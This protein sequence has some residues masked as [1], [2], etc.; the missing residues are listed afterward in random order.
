MRK[1]YWYL[2]GFKDYGPKYWLLAQLGKVLYFFRLV[3]EQEAKEHA[4][5]VINSYIYNED[6][7]EL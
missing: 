3:N 5:A 7:W 6:D 4:D 2:K 1:G